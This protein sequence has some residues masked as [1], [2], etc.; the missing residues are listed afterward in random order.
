MLEY[1]LF[2]QLHLWS[3]SGSLLGKLPHLVH[4]ID[5][6]LAIFIV[7]P[8]I[9]FIYYFDGRNV[10]FVFWVDLEFDIIIDEEV[11]EFNFLFWREFAEDEGLGLLLLQYNVW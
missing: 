4:S 9:W 7:Q 10:R 6:L 1:C 11:H 8:L 3:L 5:D 2:V